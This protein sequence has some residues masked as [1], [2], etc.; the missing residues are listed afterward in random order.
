VL[1]TP[2]LDGF[3]KGLRPGAPA[4]DAP[5]THQGQ[6]DWLLRHTGGSFTG[7]YF[8]GSLRDAEVF[9]QAEAL[10]NEAI[11]LRTLVVAP[12]GQG[13]PGMFE[14]SAGLFAARYDATPGSFYL[15]RPDQHVCARWRSFNPQ[16]VRAAVARASGNTSS[17]RSAGQPVLHMEHA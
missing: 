14:D 9:A 2:D 7:I 12:M 16:A 11:A 15:L 4:A 6:P 5:V 10:A 3:A 13:G 17:P 1:N 8:A